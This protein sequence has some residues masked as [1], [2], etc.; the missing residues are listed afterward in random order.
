MKRRVLK[1]QKSQS[2]TFGE[3][4]HGARKEAKKKKLTELY[5][6]GQF[7]E[8]RAEW[9]VELQRLCEEVYT[10]VAETKEKQESRIK[11]CLGEG[12]SATYRG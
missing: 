1:R 6:N 3:M 5:V 10:D 12:Q 4:Q 2:R 11:F 7:T 9:Q 8:D